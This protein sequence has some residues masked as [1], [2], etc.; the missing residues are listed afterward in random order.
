MKYAIF[1]TA[2]LAATFA[3]PLTAEDRLATLPHG[4]YICALPGDA[5]GLPVQEVSEH[6]FAV[7]GASSYESEGGGGTY[8]R[9]GDTVTFTRGPRKDMKL[10]ML[11]SG[12]LQWIKED[13]TLGRIRCTRVSR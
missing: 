3:A 11:G 7:T 5:T 13:G 4:R 10:K 12:M 1:A 2:A 8:L 9:V 6:N